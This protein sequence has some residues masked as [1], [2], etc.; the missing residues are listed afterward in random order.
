MALFDA[1]ISN[2]ATGRFTGRSFGFSLAEAR[3]II[4]F[5]QLSTGFDSI[6][7]AGSADFPGF[8]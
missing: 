5:S 7:R 3:T 1:P 6:G 2:A 4:A 8:P